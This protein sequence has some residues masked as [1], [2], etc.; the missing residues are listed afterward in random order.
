MARSGGPSSANH[1]GQM[2]SRQ[3]RLG[4]LL[5]H[6]GFSCGGT[7]RGAGIGSCLGATIFLR[8]ALPPFVFAFPSLWDFVARWGGAETRSRAATSYRAK[9]P[10][11][12]WLDFHFLVEAHLSRR[13]EASWDIV[14]EENGFVASCH[15]RS[16]SHILDCLVVAHHRHGGAWKKEFGISQRI[17]TAHSY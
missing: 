14:Q 9:H 2:V 11:A 15:V 10:G 6:C 12:P 5:P 3:L 17:K 4:F 16:L 7:W 1:Q 8:H 13:F